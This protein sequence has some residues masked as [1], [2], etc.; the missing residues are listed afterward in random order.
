MLEKLLGRGRGGHPT[1]MVPPPAELTGSDDYFVEVVG[2]SNYQPALEDLCR[3][4]TPDGADAYFTAVLVPERDN[5]HDYNAVRVEIEGNVVGYL[6]R[7]FAKTY[8]GELKT[9]RLADTPLACKAK[10][11][12][13][14]DRGPDDRGHFG[15]RLDISLP[16]RIEA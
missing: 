6:P 4:R 9:L 10:V 12:G 7:P 3:G 2:E 1:A 11:T 8:R 5:P 14:W 16:L 15:V 13:G